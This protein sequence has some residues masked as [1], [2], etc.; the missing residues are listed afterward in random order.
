MPIVGPVHSVISLIE[1]A[2]QE[3][4]EIDRP[5]SIGGLLEPDVF[6]GQHVAHVDPLVVPADPAVRAHQAGLEVARILQVA[7]RAV[8]GPR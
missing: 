7:R 6:L 4:P 2:Q 5:D 3:G 8:I 1:A